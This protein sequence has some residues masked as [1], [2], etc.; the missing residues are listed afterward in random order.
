MNHYVFFTTMTFLSRSTTKQHFVTCIV[1]INAIR[2]IKL[3]FSLSKAKKTNSG[4]KALKLARNVQNG[5]DMWY[6]N[7][8]TVEFIN[9]ITAKLIKI[10]KMIYVLHY[11]I[12]K[13]LLHVKLKTIK[14]WGWPNTVLF[15]RRLQL[16]RNK[17]YSNV[18]NE[19][20][21]WLFTDAI[22]QYLKC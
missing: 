6:E 16:R 13:R 2:K 8:R 4:K 5:L 19:Q 11:R 22:F 18:N 17:E 10:A 20:S 9:R 3:R 15:S 14:I 12:I 21:R 1:V 7:M